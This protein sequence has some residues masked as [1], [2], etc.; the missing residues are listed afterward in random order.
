[1]R[2]ERSSRSFL[3]VGR[4]SPI[5]ISADGFSED[6]MSIEKNV[7]DRKAA[8]ELLTAMLDVAHADFRA[9]PIE[10]RRLFLELLHDG[11]A[12]KLNLPCAK[13]NQ[14]PEVEQSPQQKAAT[15]VEEAL[16]RLAEIVD[17]CEQVPDRGAEFAES[18]AGGARS[19]AETIDRTQ[20]VTEEQNRAIQNWDAGVRAWLKDE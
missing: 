3:A 4:V 9:M 13:K 8:Q 2:W 5:G 7:A 1:V 12:E 10:Q 11:A 14:E 6:E 17:L 16:E 15:P 19:M 20:K 18:V